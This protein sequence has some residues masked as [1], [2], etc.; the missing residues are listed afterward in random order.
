MSGSRRPRIVVFD[1][2]GVLV[3][4]KSSWQY[5]HERFGVADEASRIME[6][7][8]Q[9]KI[10]YLE[11]MRLDT[12]LWIKASGGRLHRNTLMKMFE[13]VEVNPEAVQVVRRLRRLGLRIG[14]L[15]GGI[16]LL[17]M[18]VARIIGADA[19][20]ANG[21]IFDKRGYLVPGGR[22]LVG[23]DKSRPLRR[24]LWELGLEPSEAVYVGDSEWDISAFRVVAYP[25]LYGDDEKARPYVK[26]VIKRLGELVDIVEDLVSRAP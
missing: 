18:R 19:W 26:Y 6:M 3:D 5:L 8:V 4:I 24:M 17:A 9:G 11:W 20:M 25:V 13:E 14:I 15:S 22:P 2:D 12:S 23:V 7:F 1:M 10:D 21:L 16:D